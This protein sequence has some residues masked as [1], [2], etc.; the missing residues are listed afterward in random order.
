MELAIQVKKI[1][2]IHVPLSTYNRLDSDS[3]TYSITKEM[4]FSHVAVFSILNKKIFVYDNDYYKNEILSYI[5][6]KANMILLS[7]AKSNNEK[8][9]IN[10]NS[11]NKKIIFDEKVLKLSKIISKLNLPISL[12]NIIVN[13][14]ARIY[15]YMIIHRL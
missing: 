14:L 4:I 10:Y 9:H 13:L 15:K 7:S 5:K 3:L 1:C 2:Y 11:F 6:M 12:I 8:K